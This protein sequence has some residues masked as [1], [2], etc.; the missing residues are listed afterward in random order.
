VETQVLPLL[1]SGYDTLPKRYFYNVAEEVADVSGA[2]DGI[3]TVSKV[4][5]YHYYCIIQQV[6]LGQEKCEKLYKFRKR[7][8]IFL[9]YYVTYKSMNTKN[10]IEK[11]L[12]NVK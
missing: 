2:G 1:F 9:L 12:E 5:S 10:R 11:Y 3:I 7:D 6:K 8:T 4:I